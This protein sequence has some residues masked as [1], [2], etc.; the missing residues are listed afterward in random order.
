M[1]DLFDKN[2]TT[3]S[4]SEPILDVPD[5]A[6]MPRGRALVQY[7]GTRPT[8]VKPVPWWEGPYADEIRTSLAYFEP[9]GTGGPLSPQSEMPEEL[10]KTA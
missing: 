10:R 4:R 2:V 6:S 1:H 8:L 5:L 3:G 9:G 7:S